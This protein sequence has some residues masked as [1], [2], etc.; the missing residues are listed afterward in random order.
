MLSVSRDLFRAIHEGRWLKIEYR[1]KSGE[2]TKYWISILDLDPEEKTLKVEGMHLQS[3]QI[4]RFDIIYIESIQSSQIIEGSWCPVNQA[5]VSDIEVYPEKYKTVFEN[6]ANLKIL[7]YLEMCSRLDFSP[8]Y[9]DFDIVRR[10]DEDIVS[11]KKQFDLNEEQ[12][13]K[14]IKHFKYQTASD[15]KEKKNRSGKR[16]VSQLV[17]NLLSIHTPRGLYVLAY[18]KLHFDIK[19][20]CFHPDDEITVCHEFTLEG[21]KLSARR[22]LDADDYELLDN[23]EHNQE[24]I[25]DRIQKT[26]PE[27][28]IDDIPYIIGIEG[29]V[30]LDLHEEYNAILQSM[31]N[32]TAELPIRTFF[33]ELLERPKK[34]R[35]N[36]PLALLDRKVNLDQL[37]AIHNAMKFPLAYIQGPP[38]TGKT[39]TIVNTIVTAFFNDR[40]VLFSSYNNTPI[41]GVFEKLCGFYYEGR[42]IPFPV[43]R[44]GNFEK[45]KEAILYIRELMAS[46]QSLKVYSDTLDRRK[47]GRTERAAEFNRLMSKYDDLL[48][49]Y[50]RE[51]TLHRLLEHQKKQDFSLQMLNFENDMEHRQ[52][53]RIQEE[54]EKL[55]TISEEDAI[56]LLDTNDQELRQFL[57]YSSAR[58]IQRLKNEEYNEF[59]RILDI[60]D[61]GK[62]AEEL[63]RYVSES[64]NVKS[65]LKVFPVIITTCISAHKIGSP[66]VLFDLTIMDEASQCN[67]A[68]SL[69]PILRGKNLMLVG[70]P[71]QL[72]PVV[73]LDGKTNDLLKKRFHVP[74]EYDYKQN[75]VYKTFLS[76]DSVSDEIL[77]HNHYRCHRKIIDFNNRKYYSGKLKICSRVSSEKPLLFRDFP[78]AFSA[79]KNTS[80]EEAQM[81]AEFCDLNKDR[82]IG[83]ITPFVNQRLLIEKEL[84][85]R[86]L[87]NIPVGT[88]HA[89][90]GDEKDIILFS[91]AI[92]QETRQGTYDWLKNNKE[93]L[94]VATSRAR[95]QLMILSDSQSL[96]R[97]HKQNDDDDLY[98]LVQYVRSNGESAVTRRENGSRALG[99]KPF[100]TETEEA[101]LTSLTHALENIWLTQ[102]RYT[103]HKEV[104]VSQV[105]QENITSDFLFY[106]GRFDFVIYRREADREIPMFAIELDGKEHF[107]EETVR[108]RDQKKN[109]ICRAHHMELIRV[110]N[111]YARRYMHIKAILEGYFRRQH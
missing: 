5:L 37:L 74:D 95:E 76:C 67:T 61:I 3:L 80:P 75:S 12:Y 30:V 100:S 21:E 53:N 38:G 83:V 69:V 45:I 59:R 31:E 25:K 19:G 104:P 54:I 87:H 65:L 48:D 110:E 64:E 93:L 72:S 44:L 47:N 26:R 62:A 85:E 27:V 32:D 96:E 35:K 86:G 49:L 92:T 24:L 99:V 57:Y 20:H 15:E 60:Q 97:L 109:E 106:T 70:D 55:G 17:L 52:L 101:F 50:E 28:S 6:A 23:F 46:V 82:S 2:E 1:N 73:L 11:G 41:D 89:F 13:R 91:T 98:E 63:N 7:D 29:D 102:N 94:N 34:S 111:S 107:E 43:L 56:S 22:F 51:E 16:K 58:Y 84:Q 81:I 108:I 9:K 90:Q 14:L 79:K 77:L 33:G 42:R 71:Q 78:K 105:F 8:Y 103:I 36:Y 4:S 66:E 88:V 18:R 40:T 39:S 68:V 10:I